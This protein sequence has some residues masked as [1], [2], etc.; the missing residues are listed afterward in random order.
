MQTLIK[1]IKGFLG[2]LF[3]ALV[4]RTF[5]IQ[6]FVIPSGSMYP[7]LEIGDFIIVTKYTYGFSNY[8]FPFSPDLFQGRILQ[9]RQPKRGEVVV[10]R[11][12][13]GKTD[14]LL[15]KLMF[16]DESLDYIKRLIGMP[17]DKVQLINGVVH[18]NGVAATYKKLGEYTYYDPRSREDRNRKAINS[19]I[20]Y[21]ETLP[22]GETHIII[23]SIPFGEGDLDNTP[24]Y[25]V[26][27]GYYFFLGDN[28]DNSLDSRVQHVLGYVPDD[29][30]IGPA[31][32]I[33]FS[34]DAKWY[35]ITHWITGIRP[36]RIF[37]V[38]H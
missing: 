21:E 23:K 34:T 15:K 37:K 25:D 10:H 38:I 35:E 12:P 26:P 28:R 13:I 9:M 14:S 3:I 33:F 31:E 18:I 7:T 11:N 36:S 30:L 5:L 4:I 22:S 1:E 16:Q 19:A 32:L 17:G 29:H 24:E 2:A 27:E 6:P 20:E 8:S